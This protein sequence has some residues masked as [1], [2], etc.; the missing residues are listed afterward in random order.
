[1]ELR[2]QLTLFLVIMRP[3][4]KGQSFLSHFVNYKAI[5]NDLVHI[6]TT[7]TNIDF[8]GVPFQFF[9]YGEMQ[10]DNLPKPIKDAILVTHIR[11]EV[12][13]NITAEYD[14][15]KLRPW[16]LILCG[17]LHFNHVYK[18]FPLY[19]P[20]SPVNVNFDREDNKF[21]GVN[22]IEFHSINNYKINFIDLKL[23]KLIRKTINAGEAME[24]DPYH[25]VI[26][27]VTGSLDTLATVTNNELLDKKIVHKPNE[28]SKINLSDKT[29]REALKLWLEYNKIDDIDGIMEEYDSLGFIDDNT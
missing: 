15:E 1:M 19:Y 4:K 12:P 23:P 27:E 16:R 13:P 24:K 22:S 18:D 29:T 7:N 8:K 25:H 26:Y 11:G 2:F 3:L 9:P 5:T 21:Y 28:D 6:F 10:T 14:F 17:D 20:S